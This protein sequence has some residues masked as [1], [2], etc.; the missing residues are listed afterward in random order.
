MKAAK[1][2]LATVLMIL[3]VTMLFGVSPIRPVRDIFTYTTI[4]APKQQVWQVLTNF[5][6]YGQ[7]NPFYTAIE[8]KCLAGERIHV[9]VQMADRTL[10]YMPKIETVALQSELAWNEQ[11]IVPGLFDGEHR[12]MLESTDGGQTRF[13]QHD[14]YSGALVP[15]FMELYQAEAE[16][17]FRRMNDA[18][19]KRAEET[20]GN[21]QL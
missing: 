4:E 10:T 17:G 20:S 9:Q 3:G 5:S 15:L 18:L 12:F 7:W 14:R 8:G 19:K 13:V 2:I 1:A 16:T 6:D 11:P 21:T